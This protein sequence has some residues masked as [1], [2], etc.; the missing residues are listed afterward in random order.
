MAWE[1]GIRKEKGFPCEQLL[2]W[3]SGRWGGGGIIKVKE[4][5]PIT[6]ELRPSKVEID[7]C[8]FRKDQSKFV[9]D[10]YTSYLVSHESS[11]VKD[12][13]VTLR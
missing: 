1:S 6:E 5:H 13:Y 12:L 2:T 7:C 10:I 11:V 8:F 4:N 3:N 9:R